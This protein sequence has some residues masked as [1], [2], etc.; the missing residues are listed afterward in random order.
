MVKKYIYEGSVYDH[1]R[2]NSTNFKLNLLEP[3][4]EI[5]GKLLAIET[6]ERRLIL[7]L[8]KEF[9]VELENNASRK[10]LRRLINK[11]VAILRTDEGY[12]FRTVNDQ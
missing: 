8:S 5:G 12:R 9:K 7:T 4:E 1:D 10:T 11:H 3:W 2:G 6:I